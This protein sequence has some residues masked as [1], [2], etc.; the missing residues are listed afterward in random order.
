MPTW[1]MSTIQM[2]Y[3]LRRSF[4]LAALIGKTCTITVDM[5]QYSLQFVV[6]AAV[7]AVAAGVLVRLHQRGLL[8]FR[9]TV[10]WLV[11]FAIGFL[12]SLF[13][14]LVEPLAALMQ[15]SAVALVAA[16]GIAVLVAVCVQLCVSI[17][18]LQRQV[19][20]LCEEIALFS[21][22][23]DKGQSE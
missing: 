12:S 1:R 23:V 17:S 7:A 5:N 16:L 10:G 13:I 8:S 22:R 2:L 9:F 20:T 18:G 14:P 3:G 21:E 11:L 6:L 4:S 15:V 19:Q